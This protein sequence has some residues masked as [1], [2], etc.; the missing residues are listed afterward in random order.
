MTEM[1]ESGVIWKKM[2]IFSLLFTAVI[3]FTVQTAELTG[4]VYGENYK[5]LKNAR[6]S[7]SR[8]S[9]RTDASGY[10]RLNGLPSGKVL[11]T[12]EYDG[13]SEIRQCLLCEGA[14]NYEFVFRPELK[15]DSFEIPEYTLLNL[16]GQGGGIETFSEILP[17]VRKKINL[18]YSRV[19]KDSDFSYDVFHYHF[20]IK[21][22]EN[23]SLAASLVDST[24]TSRWLRNRK[25]VKSLSLHFHPDRIPLALGAC[26]D[27]DGGYYY[28]AHDHLL[29]ADQIMRFNLRTTSGNFRKGALNIG[30]LK[31]MGLYQLHTEAIMTDFRYRTLNLGVST[32]YHEIEWMA[33][34]RKDNSLHIQS[35]GLGM[36]LSW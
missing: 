9:T 23:L 3:C 26:A 17:S 4:R 21:P 28:L 14:N 10:F 2:K 35:G 15:T 32:V 29:G 7:Y 6:I 31:N 24:R 12:A 18:I 1:K 22:L 27:G 34:F 8:F 16:Y 36:Q 13:K 20:F 25:T 5:P 11:L 33:Y 19:T 30:Y